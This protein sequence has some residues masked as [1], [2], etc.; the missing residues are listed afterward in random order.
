VA[1]LKGLKMRMGGGVLGEA[2]TKLGV[3]AQHLPAGDIYQA[4]EKGTLNVEHINAYV[5]AVQQ[6]EARCDQEGPGEKVPLHLEVGIRA[7][8]EGLAHDRVD[9]TDGGGCQDKPDDVFADLG[10]EAVDA[11]GQLEQALDVVFMFL[12]WMP[13]P[14]GAR[15]APALCAAGN[16]HEAGRI[17][18][19]HRPLIHS[20]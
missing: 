6:R 2:M 11:A 8:V 10:V 12:R 16:V 5:F 3:V 19:V 17:L 15:D 9:G 4:P 20:E 7:D 1:D 14:G 18:E 13:A